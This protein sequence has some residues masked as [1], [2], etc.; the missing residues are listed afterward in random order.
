MNGHH[1]S[2]Y[3]LAFSYTRYNCYARVWDGQW[4]HKYRCLQADPNTARYD[5]HASVWN[6]GSSPKD[7]NPAL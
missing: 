3:R 6:E 2:T 5:R 7:V 4:S 1:T